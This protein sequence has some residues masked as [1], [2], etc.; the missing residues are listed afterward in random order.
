LLIT[1]LSHHKVPYDFMR[2]IFKIRKYK[3]HLKLEKSFGNNRL[4]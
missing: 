4:L 1:V 2:N 3:F